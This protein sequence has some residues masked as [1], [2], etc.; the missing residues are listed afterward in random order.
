MVSRL[1]VDV[2]HSAPRACR[3]GAARGGGLRSRSSSVEPPVSGL[4]MEL[5]YCVRRRAAGKVS[6]LPEH[7][8]CELGCFAVFGLRRS[9]RM[10]VTERVLQGSRCAQLGSVMWANRKSFQDCSGR[11]GISKGR[12]GRQLGAVDQ[13]HSGITVVP[14]RTG[15][16]PGRPGPRGAALDFRQETAPM[17][18]VED[19]CR[20]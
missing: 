13:G 9:S 6:S 17:P 14:P 12:V 3:V 2:F 11:R 1:K 8:Q 15:G 16:R 18:L 10:M 20:L 5:W 19:T 4:S 7:A